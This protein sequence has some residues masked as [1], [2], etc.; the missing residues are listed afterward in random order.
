MV[1]PAALVFD[2]NEKERHGPLLREPPR[3]VDQTLAEGLRAPSA[4]APT[5]EQKLELIR[6]MDGLGVDAA[7]LGRPGARPKALAEV[8]QIVRTIAEERLEIEL[9]CASSTDE[10][11]LR[12]LAELAQR[13]GSAIEVEI[14]IGSGPLRAYA[15]GGPANK[16]SG[17]ARQ[18]VAFAVGNSLVASLVTEDTTRAHPRVLD[19]LYRAA[20]E[21]GVSRIVLTDSTGH[22]T[23]DGLRSLIAF[24]RSILRGLD[25]VDRVELDWHGKDDRGLA[26]VLGLFALEHGI[27]RVHASALGLGERAGGTPIDLL[28]LNLSML[29]QLDPE[30]HDLAGLVAYVEKVAEYTGV[31]IRESYPLAGRDVFRSTNDAHAAAIT[32][33]IA[34]GDVELADRVLS[35]VPAGAFGRTPSL[36]IGVDSGRNSAAAWLRAH[37]REATDDAIER[38]LAAALA[39]GGR[40]DDAAVR[41]LFESA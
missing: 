19:P 33:A 1:D 31:A 29:A 2:W 37:D 12:A 22:A 27:D 34:K 30:R 35:S 21:A 7:A 28:L 11:E 25:A 13:T 3:C 41:G 8:E 17:A 16:T 40:L 26:L 24:S 32:K 38:I 23:P 18:A 10:V 15:E 14:A 6:R 20:I 5:V 36:E 9:I 4:R 39:H